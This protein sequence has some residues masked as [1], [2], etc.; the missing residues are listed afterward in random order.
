VVAARRLAMRGPLRLRRPA[1]RC[2][3]DSFGGV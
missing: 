3:A 2:C 1:R